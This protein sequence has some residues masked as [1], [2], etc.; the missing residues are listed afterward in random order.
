M[1]KGCSRCTVA[2]GALTCA[3]AGLFGAPVRVED[4]STVANPASSPGW[5]IPGKPWMSGV[6]SWSHTKELPAPQCRGLLLSEQPRGRDVV[7]MASPGSSSRPVLGTSQGQPDPRCEAGT[8]CPGSG[9]QRVQ[10]EEENPAP[11]EDVSPSAGVIFSAAMTAR[12]LL[13]LVRT[14]CR[15]GEGTLGELT[16]VCRSQRGESL[17]SS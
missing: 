3:R 15:A 7:A 12:S 8:S 13:S 1:Q 16:S 17:P 6:R 2:I 11:P 4:G 9:F 14:L 5:D 10:A